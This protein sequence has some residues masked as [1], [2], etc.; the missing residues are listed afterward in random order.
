M[1]TGALEDHTRIAHEG[2][3]N[4]PH[5]DKKFAAAHNRDKHVRKFHDTEVVSCACGEEFR[6]AAKKE[7]HERACVVSRPGATVA[8]KRRFSE[9]CEE[10]GDRNGA[11][12]QALQEVRTEAQNKLCLRCCGVMYASP[13]SLRRHK[14]KKHKGDGAVE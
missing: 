1:S 4:C 13:D 7:E 8:V 2:L 6:D 9:L 3:I 14:R 11:I 10:S 12:A 5:C